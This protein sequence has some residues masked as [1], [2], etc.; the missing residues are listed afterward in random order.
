MS[1]RDQRDAP[2]VLRV[3]KPAF[4]RE[5]GTAIHWLCFPNTLREREF[6]KLFRGSMKPRHRK[7]GQRAFPAET[8]RRRGERR[9]NPKQGG[10]KVKDSRVVAGSQG[11]SKAPPPFRRLIDRD[12]GRRLRAPRTPA[13][14]LQT[15]D[16]RT[17]ARRDQPQ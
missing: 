12:Y 5:S 7:C 13:Q 16:R 14:P 2:G 11:R 4:S 6:R 10:R 1:Q 15:T 9:E 3:E 17:A 8:Q